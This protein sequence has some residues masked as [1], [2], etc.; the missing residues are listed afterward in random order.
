[1]PMYDCP[2]EGGWYEPIL[3]IGLTYIGYLSDQYRLVA[4]PSLVYAIVG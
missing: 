2:M 1:M 4:P 3:F